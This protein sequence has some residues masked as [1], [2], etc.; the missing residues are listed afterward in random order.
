MDQ[1][2]FTQLSIETLQKAVN[3]ATQRGNPE[4][5]GLHLL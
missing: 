1:T 4:V 5:E 2:Q 3:E